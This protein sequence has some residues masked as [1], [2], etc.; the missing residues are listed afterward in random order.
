MNC[1]NCE[2]PKTFSVSKEQWER[3][4]LFLTSEPGWDG[5]D[6]VGPP[7]RETVAEALQVLA[8]LRQNGINKPCMFMGASGEIEIAHISR[9]RQI[10]LNVEC[11]GEGQFMVCWFDHDRETAFHIFNLTELPE[12]FIQA[13]RKL[14]ATEYG[15]SN[16]SK[17][18]ENKNAG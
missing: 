2:H 9:D 15:P 11:F 12:P 14:E 8:Y 5:G 4:E 16:E 6:A 10:Y 17:A 13:M 18:T 7:K 1:A 3:L